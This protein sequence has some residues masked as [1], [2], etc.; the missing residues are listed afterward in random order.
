MSWSGVCVVQN[1]TESGGVFCSGIRD[2]SA[3]Y[4]IDFR[5]YGATIKKNPGSHWMGSLGKPLSWN[6]CGD[7]N[8]IPD[9]N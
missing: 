3:L 5:M 8:K 9:T 2:V 6:G 7:M 1:E 4:N